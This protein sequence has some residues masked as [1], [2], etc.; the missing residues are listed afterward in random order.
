MA[1]IILASGSPRRRHL[2]EQVGIPCEI[3]ES[4]ADETASGP[5]QKQ[6]EALAIRKAKAVQARVKGDAVIIA[7]DTLV[8]IDELILGKPRD[9]AEAFHMLKTLQGRKHTVITGVALIKKSG[10]KLQSQSF[11]ETAAVYFRP[12][13]DNEIN[14]YITTG[15]PF[16]KAGAYGIQGVGALLVERIEGDFYTVV[17]L[18]LSRLYTSL[19][20]LGVWGM[21]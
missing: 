4:G 21:Y 18:P 10:P 20:D 6:A 11:V 14:G 5:P 16:D 17:G 9:A 7:A 13:T 1:K 8:V 12:L 15:E 2:L 19:V 3:M